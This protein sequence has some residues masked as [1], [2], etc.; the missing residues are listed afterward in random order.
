MKLYNTAASLHNPILYPPGI[1]IVPPLPNTKAA[2]R[3]LTGAQFGLVF[4]SYLT[5][6]HVVDQCIVVAGALGLAPLAPDINV[7]EHRK[8]ISDHLG[9]SMILQS[10]E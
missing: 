4:C 9:C 10:L 3:E 6:C 8:Q 7:G 1:A 2:L 5:P